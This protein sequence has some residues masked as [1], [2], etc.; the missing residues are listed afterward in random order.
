MGIARHPSFELQLPA[1][2]Q[3]AS[4]VPAP[5]PRV[6]WT[7]N[8]TELFERGACYPMASFVVLYF[9][10]MGM[11]HYWPS[12]LNSVLWPR[13]Y[14]LPIPAHGRARVVRG[15]HAARQGGRPG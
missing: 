9:G 2:S 5:F 11:G 7:A 6:F 3:S 4:A 12:T 1:M 14:F 15:R 8:V 10:R 13:V